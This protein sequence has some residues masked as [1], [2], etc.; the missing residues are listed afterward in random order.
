MET[1]GERITVCHE[2]DRS[3]IT[4]Q[5]FFKRHGRNEEI[6]EQEHRELT[7]RLGKVDAELD[8]LK[9]LILQMLET[10]DITKWPYTLV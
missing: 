3:E 6:L 2:I 9:E 7:D 10:L 8:Q 1:L 5:V 4:R